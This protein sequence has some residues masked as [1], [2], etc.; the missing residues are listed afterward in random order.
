MNPC[1]EFVV[2]TLR[3]LGNDLKGQELDDFRFHLEACDNCRAHLKAESAP[4]ETLRRSRPLYSAPAALRD[5]V[6]PEP[7][8]S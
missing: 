2:K 6:K 3:Y 1:D 4:S 8:S 5:R 7:F